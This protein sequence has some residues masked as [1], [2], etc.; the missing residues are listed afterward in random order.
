MKAHKEKELLKQ[1]RSILLWKW[2]P[3]GINDVPEAHDEYDSYAGGVPRL[4]AS[5]ASE[6]Q[7]IK[8]LH[9]LETVAMGLPSNIEADHLR[10]AVKELL[11]LKNGES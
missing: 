1:I 6:H 3:I 10:M 7:L 5:G 8:H 2:D 4:L 11:K 9:Q